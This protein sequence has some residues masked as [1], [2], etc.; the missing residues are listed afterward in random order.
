MKKHAIIP[1]FIPHKG[2]P[3]DCVFCNQKKIT[4]RNGKV[5]ME[6]V[7]N[8]IET[9]LSTLEESSVETIEVAF[10]GGSFTGIPMEEQSAFLSVAKEYKDRGRI[11]KIHMSTRP[12]YINEEILD[13]LKKYDADTIELGVQSFDDEVL[14]KAGRG[15]DSSIV[16][17]SSQL[18]KDYGFELGI[19]L[20]IG[21]PGD[22]METAIYSAQETVKINP[23]IARLYPTIVINDTE[24]YN[25][26][27]RGEYKPLSQ[28][29][30]IKRTKEMYKIID[31]AGINIIRV[32][33]KSSDIINENGEISGNTYHPA[34]RQLV[35]GEIA[36]ERVEDQLLAAGLAGEADLNS[37]K[38]DQRDKGRD[39]RIKVDVFSSPNSFSN[40]VGHK[41]C[42]KTYFAHKYPH[43]SLAFRTDEE[44]GVNRYRIKVKE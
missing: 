27:M 34:F 15:H 9:Y 35:E 23:S 19:Q 26:N 4:A 44:L 21:L 32:G 17:K 22:T 12:D 2:C 16:Y 13:N 7:I 14:K 43:L 33:L 39:C 8:T 37:A 6:D 41:A 25:M 36:K 42:N 10:F 5:T 40:M 38:A 29:E 31:G 30:A 28:E 1:I 24:L 11:D 3:N 18:I 20:M